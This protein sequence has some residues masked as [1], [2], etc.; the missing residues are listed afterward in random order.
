LLE[1][2]FRNS[3]TQ[4]HCAC[5]FGFKAQADANLVRQS[6]EPKSGGP[7]PKH[8]RVMKGSKG[9][10]QESEDNLEAHGTSQDLTNARIDHIGYRDCV[11]RWRVSQSSEPEKGMLWSWCR[12]QQE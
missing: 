7:R 2:L 3:R 11:E 12:R 6:D 1:A 5:G 8:I 4:S 10:Q 9:E